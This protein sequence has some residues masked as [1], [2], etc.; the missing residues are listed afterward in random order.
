M[1]WQIRS[2]DRIWSCPSDVINIVC[3]GRRGRPISPGCIYP[4][5]SAHF[6]PFLLS[7]SPAHS[8]KNSLAT[9]L[10][11]P[12]VSCSWKLFTSPFLHWYISS[13]CAT[14]QHNEVLSYF[15]R[16]G[17]RCCRRQRLG[18]SVVPRVELH[19]VRLYPTSSMP[20][21]TLT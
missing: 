21:L 17:G 2:R 8:S 15:L 19:N 10:L 9:V 20:S 3:L 7:F 1:T 4:S 6:F 5:A 16:L 13:I 11:V 12:L 14:L 18:E